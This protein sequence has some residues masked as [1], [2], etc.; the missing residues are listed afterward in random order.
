MQKSCRGSSNGQNKMDE[1]RG[2]PVLAQAAEGIG[3]AVDERFAK[4]IKDKIG[5]LL[6][7]SGEL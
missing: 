6:G 4:D 5:Q 7:G 1:E 3:A 2:N